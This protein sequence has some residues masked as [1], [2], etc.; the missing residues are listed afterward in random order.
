M[1]TDPQ[2]SWE[3]WIGSVLGRQAEMS[4][5]EDVYTYGEETRALALVSISEGPRFFW[6]LLFAT[7]VES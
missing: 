3:I 1:T 5:Y 6:F 7:H 4:K 2:L